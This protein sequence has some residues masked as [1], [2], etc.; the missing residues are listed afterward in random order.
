M[1]SCD[2][3]VFARPTVVEAETSVDDS[4][5]TAESVLED[6]ESSIARA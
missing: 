5:V 2:V 1:R 4:F 6:Q 3:A